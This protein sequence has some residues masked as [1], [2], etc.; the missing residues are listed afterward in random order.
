MMGRSRP[1]RL[2]SR[3]D[4]AEFSPPPDVAVGIGEPRQ[5][6]SRRRCPG[7][8]D[9]RAGKIRLAL[10]VRD[11]AEEARVSRSTA[12]F[13][14]WRLAGQG[15]LRLAVREGAGTGRANTWVLQRPE[16]DIR[17]AHPHEE[18]DMSVRDTHANDA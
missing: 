6:R 12:S 16:A 5:W 13:A 1:L 7:S 9:E 8:S 15:W 17:V 10:S 11:V 2:R 14:M 18:C 4:G 3:L